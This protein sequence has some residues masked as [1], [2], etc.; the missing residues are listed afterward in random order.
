MALAGK[1]IVVAL[2]LACLG[3]SF[4]EVAAAAPTPAE[5]ETARTLVHSGRKKM[6]AGDT[7]SALDDFSTAHAIMN[8]PTTGR[9]VGKAQLELG[10]LLEARDT[11]LSVVRMPLERREPTAF[12]AARKE[13]KK[14]A[15]AIAPR[16]PSVRIS[17]EGDA[18]KGASVFI[19]GSRVPEKSIGVAFKVNPGKHEVVARNG[20]LEQTVTIEIAEK[21][22]EEV[23]LRLEHPPPPAA[24][25]KPSDPLPTILIVS[26][27]GV[28]GAAAVV[29][30]VTGALS[31]DQAASVSQRC[32]LGQCPPET[33]QDIADAETLGT[34]STVGFIVAGAMAAAGIVGLTLVLLSD[35]DGD[36]RA[37]LRIH[38]SPAGVALKG[39]F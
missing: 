34:V 29:G 21:E 25:D 23:E 17:V 7:Q 19:D 33:H 13:C 11:F 35:D 2:A 28:A 5:K 4:V 30:S 16:I 6:K 8:V 39:W 27:F 3:T 22:T 32:T 18:S 24:P 15:E 36:E 26:A 10:L 20:E 1:C 14:L 38:A 9:E 31:I 12:R 37:A